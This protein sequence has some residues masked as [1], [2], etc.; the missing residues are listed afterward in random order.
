MYKAG[1]IQPFCDFFYTIYV[2]PL[3]AHRVQYQD[4]L[5]ASRPSVEQ[6]VPEIGYKNPIPE[7]PL[8]SQELH[9]NL[10][11]TAVHII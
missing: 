7:G 4:P 11:T 9:N 2:S 8:R 10:E 5:E 6:N 1:K 3:R